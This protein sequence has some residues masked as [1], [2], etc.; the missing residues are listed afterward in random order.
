MSVSPSVL[1]SIPAGVVSENWIKKL[2]LHVVHARG[3]AA[4]GYFEAY[5]DFS[6][7]TIASPFTQA[8]KK[9]P[10]F[11]RFS[12]VAGSRGSADTARDVHGFAL[13]MYTDSGN[14]D[15]VGNTVAPFFIQDAGQFPDLVHAVKPEPDREIPQA[16]TA[17]DTAWDFFSSNPSSLHTL[18]WA[19]SP[20]GIPRSF[21][22]V[23]GFGV[24]TFRWVNADG[25]SKL[26]KYHFKT[27][28]GLASLTWDE[29]QTVAGQDGD[30]HRAD[31]HENIEAG[32]FPEWEVGVQ[33]MNEEDTLKF[34]FDLL[35]PTK[36]VPEE[37]V[38]VT[39]IGKL[40]LNRNP[41]NYFAETEQ[42]MFCPTNIIRGI[43]YS[44]DP[45][46]QGR[47]FSYKD[48]ALNRN[49]GN[50]NFQQ[51]PINRPRVPVTNNHRDGA[52]Q[53]YIPINVVAYSDNA[54]QNGFPQPAN[55]T[56]GNGFFTAL[57]RK[58]V[59]AH[60]IRNVSPTF[61][62]YWTQPRMFWN[63]LLPAEQQMLV[64]AA[65]FELSKVKSQIVKENTL[66]QFNRI[67]NELAT[68][69]A[70]GLG[71]QAPAPEPQYYHNTSTAGMS[72]FKEPLPTAKGMKVA[73]LASSQ[74]EKSVSQALQIK[75]ALKAKGINANVIG[76]VLAE[77][78]DGAYVSTHAAVFDGVVVTDAA[79]KLLQTPSSTFYPPNRPF[80]LV[81]DAYHFGKPIAMLGNNGSALKAIAKAG[82][83]GVY[84]NADA[85]QLANQMEEGLKTF[86]FLNRF[87]VDGQQ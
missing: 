4:H 54:L 44:E 22:H 9:T 2:T 32:N 63:S 3:V 86:K 85:Q 18:M 87:P 40:V 37:V 73:I 36:I 53:T 39:P 43:D 72:I 34:G 30:F 5:N 38:P 28:Q 24:H 69:V 19:M 74:N 62:D 55:M 71:L 7:L 50:P 75:E 49:G 23:N 12:T 47:L 14:Y 79:K 52:Q 8:G 17:H 42:V 48:A 20:H 61:L 31:L 83:P 45:L 70:A 6:N 56:Q 15:I 27:K 10:V 67:S 77:N 33:I 16:A 29:A 76:E 21:R 58:T 68:R 51:I 80:N 11:L 84:A 82:E 59:D 57:S 60:Y 41:K 25:E 66:K 35:D 46:L 81:S 13:K 65:R 26:I 78:I 1:V 64:N